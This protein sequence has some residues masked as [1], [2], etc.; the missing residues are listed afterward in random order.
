ML[1]RRLAPLLPAMRRAAARETTRIPRAAGL[2]GGRIALV[3]TC[4]PAMVLAIPPPLAL[5]LVMIRKPSEDGM[6]TIT[7]ASMAMTLPVL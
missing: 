5:E 3:T 2:A 4:S 7:R 1:A 6:V